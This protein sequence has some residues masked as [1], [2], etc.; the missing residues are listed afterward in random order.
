MT[1]GCEPGKSAEA[2][3]TSELKGRTPRGR[4]S[5]TEANNPIRALPLQS[6]GITAMRGVPEKSDAGFY[7]PVA[8]PTG[9]F[10][11]MALTWVAPRESPLV[12]TD[13]GDSALSRPS[14]M[15]H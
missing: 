5:L 13:G 2:E 8:S 6:K 1:A 9:I 3:W 12:P 14:T 10:V 11:S 15:D 7:L 4:V